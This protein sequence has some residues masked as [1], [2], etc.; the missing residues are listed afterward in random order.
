M[1]P[2]PLN[3]DRLRENAIV[4]I[5]PPSGGV[6]RVSDFHATIIAVIESGAVLHPI[7]VHS[8]LLP[9]RADDVFLSF[10]H[11]GQLVGLKGTL[12]YK[13][14]S[15][16]FQTADGVHVRRRRYSRADVQLPVTLKRGDES[17]EGTTVNLAPEGVLINASMNVEL[18]DLLELTFTVPGQTQPLT[19]ESKVVRHAGRL[20]AL[21]FGGAPSGV[22]AAIAEF[23]VDQRAALLA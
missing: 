5:S 11:N 9:A 7:D 4:T 22:R 2:M 20:V 1:V 12:T 23:V 8:E 19:L 17:F 18:D 14:G 13:N 16:R 21:H 6:V 3:M 15:L 10:V